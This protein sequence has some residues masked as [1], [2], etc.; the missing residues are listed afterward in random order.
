LVE[1]I[2]SG[3]RPTLGDDDADDDAPAAVAAAARENVC[4]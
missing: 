3:E 2:D 4:W 1:I